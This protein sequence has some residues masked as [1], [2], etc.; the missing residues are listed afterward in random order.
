VPQSRNRELPR[1]SQGNCQEMM[2]KTGVC[3][4]VVFSAGVKASYDAIAGYE[5]N[6]DVISHSE[7]D[8]D[9]KAM[10]DA[11]SAKDL[12][13]A[14]LIY[15]LGGNSGP[16]ADITITALAAD[17][18]AGAE[19]KQGTTAIGKIYKGPYK[20][21][22]TK[23]TVSYA[24]TVKCMV[25]GLAADKQDPSGCFTV[26]GGDITV[27]GTSIGAATAV[28]NKYRT[29]QGFSTGAY[30][31]MK[32]HKL[33]NQ[34]Y[35]YYGDDG[36]KEGAY[37]N[38]R[39]MAGL[40]GTGICGNCD[41]K[42]KGEIAKKTS[43][44]MNVWMYVIREFEDAIDDCQADCMNCN[45][46]PVHAWDEGVAFYAGSLEKTDGSGKG[47]MIHALAEKRC[48]NFKTCKDGA[49]GSAKVNNDLLPLFNSGRDK[50]LGSKCSEVRPIV[51]RII[52]L[53]SVPIVQGSLRYAYKI[54]YEWGKHVAD[55]KYFAEGAAFSA[56]ILPRIDHCNKADAKLIADNMNIEVGRL[57]AFPNKQDSFAAVKKAFE[58]NY[59]CMGITCEDI[60]GLWSVDKYMDGFSPCTHT[61]STGGSTP[62]ATTTADPADP[63]NPADPADTADS[64]ADKTAS[65]AV[66]LK[67]TLITA[68]VAV[69]AFLLEAHL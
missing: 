57:N 59:K 24:S 68:F 30:A 32:T 33:Y 21:G 56:A 15:T 14:K 37:A 53:M 67:P 20:A 63:A 47:A 1:S 36:T 27:G 3:W 18:P 2:L 22:A 10:D 11:V 48:V 7:V 9:Q 62:V 50:L 42:G 54:G 58:D 45:D 51:D 16:K 39:V 44:Y 26:G 25:G 69:F 40:D 35:K 4:V 38:K 66:D 6:S 23:I 12:A 19:V 41:A 29:L 49:S 13:A 8:K 55:D 28:T 43:A 65:A 17:A 52:D 46:D 64:V 5:P 31:K 60:G 34:Y 61:T